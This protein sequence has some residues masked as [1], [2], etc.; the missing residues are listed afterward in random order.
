MWGRQLFV[1]FIIL[2]SGASQLR[3]AE[4]VSRSVGAVGKEVVTSRYVLMN[5]LIEDEL[6]RR[7]KA[8]GLMK[9][10]IKSRLFMQE[11]TAVLIELAISR[12]SK[13]FPIA[14]VQESEV[15]SQMQKF[16]KR[17]KGSSAWKKLGVTSE[18]L[19]LI[20]S[21]KLMSKK[22]IKFKV[23]SASLPVSDMEAEEYFKKN[24]FKFEKYG[25]EKFKKNI[26]SFLNKRRV[27]S[28]LK[29]WFEVLQ[30]KYNIRNHLSEGVA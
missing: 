23:D 19:K 26:K 30:I 4:L 6:Y 20:L 17:M 9:L 13:S 7:G 15:K 14:Q 12:E 27:Y 5:S 10:D 18:E 22:F 21:R 8:R 28:R 1:L 3:A 2:L 24:R 11:T 25:F 16:S 29:E